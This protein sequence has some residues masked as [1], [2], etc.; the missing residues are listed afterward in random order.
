MSE[1]SDL[2]AGDGNESRDIFIHNVTIGQTILVSKNSSGVLADGDSDYPAVSENGRYVVFESDA[3]NLVDG[4]TNERRDVF[5]HDLWTGATTRVSLSF[6]GK[7]AE[8]GDSR[9]PAISAD[10]RYVAFQSSAENLVACD[11]NHRTDIFVRDMVAGTTFRASVGAYGCQS[12]GHSERAGITGDGRYVIF[13]TLAS[14]LLDWTD[15]EDTNSQRDV[16]VRDTQALSTYRVSISNTGAEGDGDSG[17]YGAGLSSDGQYAVFESSAENLVNED[18]NE[19]SDIFVRDRIL[20]SITK[21][22]L[23]HYWQHPDQQSEHPAISGDGRWVAFESE[24]TTL[25]PGDD[26]HYR[27]IFLRD[28]L[29]P[30]PMVTSLDPTNGDFHGGTRVSV[31]GSNF[32][33]GV[34]VTIDGL[35]VLNLIRVSDTLLTFVTPAHAVGSVEVTVRNPDGTFWIYPVGAGSGFPGY[36]YRSMAMPWM[37]LL[38]L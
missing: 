25:V 11:D 22:N 4:D 27:D 18:G 15:Q 32:Q 14:N 9:I 12:N 29:W 26:N 5:R 19:F 10:G 24:A 35:P 7:E 28:Y 8:E 34:T 30:G 33:P 6:Q 20:A 17:G 2:V 37:Y 23:G 3:T 1:A 16:Y 38:T 13:D 21:E 36:I 31:N